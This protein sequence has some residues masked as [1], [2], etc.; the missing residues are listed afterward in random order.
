[1]N[2]FQTF[3]L[4][5]ILLSSSVLGQTPTSY[6]GKWTVKWLTGAKGN[7][8]EATLE[9][10]GSSGKFRQLQRG[11]LDPCLVVEAPVNAEK[12]GDELL[13]TAKYSE[14]MK[15]CSDRTIKFKKVGDRA[16]EGAFG[17]SGV[18]VTAVKD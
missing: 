12:S 13:V 16:L 6:D 9:L 1:M 14:A 2:R 17:S 4:T 8:T 18:Q 7:P 10:N 3:A 11:K 5:S 15:G